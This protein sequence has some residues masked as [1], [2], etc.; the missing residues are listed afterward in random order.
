[1]ANESRVKAAYIVYSV[2]WCLNACSSLRIV[3]NST[4]CSKGCL[5][6]QDT[7]CVEHSKKKKKAV[8]E[9]IHSSVCEVVLSSVYLF[10]ELL[11]QCIYI[12]VRDLECWIA[13][14]VRNNKSN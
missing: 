9:K 3:M 6:H 11:V 12:F 4:L 13:D 8:T 14:S 1:M 7:H 2:F 10:L 5:S